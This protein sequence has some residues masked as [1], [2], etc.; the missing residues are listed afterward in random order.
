MVGTATAACVIGGSDFESSD[1]LFAPSLSDDANGW[2]S[3][4]VENLLDQ[5][6]G[7][8]CNY[9]ADA[10]SA[11][12]VGMASSEISSSA[13]LTAKWKDYT[14]KNINTT[15]KGFAGIVANPRVISPYLN[16]GSGS[17]QY[18]FYGNGQNVSVLTYSVSGLV[19]NSSVTVSVDVYNLL[20]A[21]NL[22]KALLVENEGITDPDDL[23]T[24]IKLG[25][26]LSFTMLSDNAG[27]T[28]GSG[29]FT[30]K[31]PQLSVSTSM[32]TGMM[33]AAGNK[34]T[35]DNLGW[36]ESQTLT[37]TAMADASGNVTFY[38]AGTN[39]DFGPLAL[40]N[41]RIEGEVESI[42]RVVGN[43]CPEM[44]AVVKLNS[45]F[46][47]G[48]V[49]S[50][51]E[52]TTG[53]TSKDPVMIFLPP[54]QGPYKI[55]C[56][57]TT[58]DGCE[59]T[60]TH[61]L[62]VGECCDDGKGNPMAL[63]DIYLDD[64]G[65]F[66][67]N[68]YIYRDIKGREQT[69]K[70]TEILVGNGNHGYCIDDRLNSG[71][72]FAKELKFSGRNFRNGAYA[73]ATENAYNS[74]STMF[75]AS[76]EKGGAFLQID[77]KGKD[78]MDKVV[79]EQTISD[80]CSERLI[81]FSAAVGAI[82]KK[83]TS[84]FETNATI[85]VRLVNAKTDEVIL[86]DGNPIE[87][88]YVLDKVGWVEPRKTY[89]FKLPEGVDEVKIQIISKEDD[90]SSAQRGDIALDDI[91]F[92]VCTP[93]SVE[94]VASSMT[95]DLLNLCVD[96]NLVLEAKIMAKGYF[97]KPVAGYLFQYAKKD[98]N[99]PTFDSALDWMDLGEVQ[100]EDSYTIKD[101]A[102]HYAFANVK[103]NENV[104]FR[105]VVGE[106]DY[107]KNQRALWESLD[108]VSPCRNVSFS[109]IP[110]KASLNCDECEPVDKASIISANSS[111]VISTNANGEKEVV[112]CPGCVA[113]LTTE[114]FAPTDPTVMG[115]SVG[116]IDEPRK[117][118]ASWHKGSK[119]A[120]GVSGVSYTPGDPVSKFNVEWK[121]PDWYYLLVKDIEFSGDDSKR[122]WKWDSIHVM[123][124]EIPT[125]IVTPL[126]VCENSAKL[127]GTLS[128]TPQSVAG[129]NDATDF[130]LVWYNSKANGAI[131]DSQELSE[132]TL[133]PTIQTAGSSQETVYTYYVLQRLKINP[134]DQSA[135]VPVTVT[136]NAKPK[137]TTFVA[138]PKC[139]GE[140]QD[141]KEMFDVNIEN[142]EAQY[143]K[144]ETST[145]V[146]SVVTEGGVYLVKG[147]YVINKGEA[148]EETCYSDQEK[149]EVR[150]HE[151]S[152]DIVGSDRTCPNE[153]VDLDFDLTVGGG[154][155][156]SDVNYSWSN[157]LNYITG[158]RK[159]YNTGT[160]GLDNPNASMVVSV[161]V[162]SSACHGANAVKKLLTIKVGDGKLVGKIKFSETDN[163]EILNDDISSDNLTFN[164]C[165]GFVTVEL[166]EVANKNG[167]TY[168]LS[169][170]SSNTGTFSNETDGSAT[171][172][173]EAGTYTVS[174]VNECQTEFSFEIVDKS[175]KAQ[176]KSEVLAICENQK[177]WAEI[178]DF[179]GPDNTVI[180]WQHDGTPIVGETGMLLDLNSAKASDSG[181]YSYSLLSAGCRFDQEIAN[182]NALVVKPLVQFD[183]TS[184]KDRYEVVNGD[185]LDIDLKFTVP[186]ATDANQLGAT[187]VEW[188]DALNGL[189][190]TG[191]HLVLPIQK[192]Y[193]IHVI[194]A[195]DNAFYCANDTNIKV[196]VDARLQLKCELDTTIMCQGEMHKLVVDTTGTGTVL[197]EN[198]LGLVATE[199]VAGQSPRKLTLVKKG[200]LLEAEISPDKDATYNV[201]Y[202]YS[203]GNQDESLA[204][205]LE[206]N[207]YEPM[208][209]EFGVPE[210]VC[211]DGSESTSVSI[212]TSASVEE[213]DWSNNPAGEVSGSM[214]SVTFTPVYK[215]SDVDPETKIY[216]VYAKNKVCQPLKKEV[217]VKIHKPLEGQIV[218]PSLV[219]GYD[220][221]HLN[222]LTYNADSYQWVYEETGDIYNEAFISLFPMPGIANFSLFVSR[223]KCK[224]EEHKKVEVRSSPV[225]VSVDSVAMR[226]V[227]IHLEE[228]SSAGPYSYIID[229][230]ES[231]IHVAESYRSDITYGVH[232][233]RV[234]D[235][236]G[237]FSD[238]TFKVPYPGIEI[239]IFITPNG[240][241]EN[242]RFVVKGL[243]EGY[244]D[245]DVRIFDRWGKQLVAYKAGDDKDW[246][247]IYNGNKMPSTD[248]WYEIN[249]QEIDKVY[250]GHFTLLR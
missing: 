160:I 13:T 207:V 154:L 27:L 128:A 47:K 178:V 95:E 125:P 83:P 36:G 56:V 120:V 219:C 126:N 137:L 184:I 136:I 127:T 80:L 214:S 91:A 129:G 228:N 60:S 98:L 179:D 119:N 57:A 4:D 250:T 194:V 59:S 141:L 34:K 171:L 215:D 234:V 114:A 51:K 48:T 5:E 145:A 23:V 100:T 246:D 182:G 79:Y 203:A 89:D 10:T 70:A 97:E 29:K 186:S 69:V 231:S 66:S 106:F 46:P 247:G 174:Y 193:N 93:P 86:A 208:E 58:P 67:G 104:N 9:F 41:L 94:M 144:D 147:S 190:E 18:V 157:D 92:R 148:D 8:S 176:S 21:D 14:T 116:A 28:P 124:A 185:N 84:G 73:I 159:T 99:D 133:S 3:K 209:V 166:T 150:F 108:E 138:D 223:G 64:F 115:I 164:S 204:T 240:D 236:V 40:D 181:I 81:S 33:P 102:S 2:F 35:T 11:V 241:G 65:R 170:A 50:W 54:T 201:V 130:E 158:T 62:I 140:S 242:D 15:S 151:L 197:H 32:S 217:Q 196:D 110:I 212:S 31:A 113:N 235:E 132:I 20:S 131:D 53:Q 211:G 189:D 200:D 103:D 101:P 156:E 123:V 183:K 75:D 43:P 77:M 210:E 245:A 42:I 165:G 175:A 63:T 71:S 68:T 221:L 177:W 22:E 205:P 25:R 117:Y 162:S 107:L 55:T 96:D 227:E 216:T 244:P 218:A 198:E 37:Y 19:P 206:M 168:M 222:A 180:E 1:V 52:T 192:D 188:I 187:D 72:A 82:N 224:A 167:G 172:S 105:V 202:T 134:S 61:S 249:I 232:S 87:D 76:D 229:G 16:E 146:S 121:D 152:G 243:K 248:Y 199:T 24:D 12:Y 237:C 45:E 109:T 7:A 112:L 78:W 220:G 169:G 161:E 149:L 44:P 39:S 111:T 122:C 74:P 173:L 135:P 230:N 153:P 26:T 90:Y 239:P 30:S 85:Q 88:T 195:S 118:V 163:T 49:Y 155:A 238:T 226:T 6:C 142:C 143:V 225:V 213:L 139:L 191:S 233:L 38:F 17:D